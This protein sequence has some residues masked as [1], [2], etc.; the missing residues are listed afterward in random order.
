MRIRSIYKVNTFIFPITPLI[1]S[2]FFKKYLG[3]I[4]RRPARLVLIPVLD[5]LDQNHTDQMTVPVG[6]IQVRTKWTISTEKLIQNVI[7]IIP[8]EM[9]EDHDVPL[10]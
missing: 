7:R 10:Y 6:G 2:T 3:A 1:F 5:V 4:Y 9:K 8:F